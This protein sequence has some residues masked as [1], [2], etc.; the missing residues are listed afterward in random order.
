MI[1]RISVNN[2]EDCGE[3]VSNLVLLLLLLRLREISIWRF[4][5]RIV[6]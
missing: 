5:V 1:F 4:N 2:W 3:E 6:N